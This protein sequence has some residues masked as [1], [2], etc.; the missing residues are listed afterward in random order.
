MFIFEKSL[1]EHVGIEESIAN[2]NPFFNMVSKGKEYFTTEEILEE[3]NNAAKIGA[4]RFILKEGNEPIAVLEY[5]LKNK[6]DQ[7]TWLGLLQI[8]KEYQGKGYGTKILLEFEEL[9]KNKQVE[10]Y[11]I[12]VIAE[13]EPALR[14]WHKH[15]FQRINS[16]I[17]EDGKEFI[18]CEKEL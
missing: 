14:F 4:E 16:I 6:S 18:I 17:N 9:M 5:L 13:N 11:R 1:P 7:C 15:G 8:K 10:K 2:S 12:G 3:I